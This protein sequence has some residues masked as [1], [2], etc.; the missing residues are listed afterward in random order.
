MR[1]LVLAALILSG[2]V[3][4]AK[5]IEEAFPPAIRVS[6]EFPAVQNAG[7]VIVTYPLSFRLNR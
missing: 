3:A 6:T 7:I 5:T 2:P 4:H 1:L